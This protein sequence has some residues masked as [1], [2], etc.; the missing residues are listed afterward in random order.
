MQLR[1]Q[2]RLREGVEGAGGGG[3]GGTRGAKEPRLA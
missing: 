1:V 2:R 3:G